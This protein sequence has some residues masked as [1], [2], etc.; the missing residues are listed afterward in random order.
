[1]ICEFVKVITALWHAV[2][3]SVIN[4]QLL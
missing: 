1:M 3:N 4:I 2:L